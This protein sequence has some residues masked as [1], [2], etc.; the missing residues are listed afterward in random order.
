MHDQI[1]S[2][3]LLHCKLL[4]PK[5]WI[6]QTTNLLLSHM[7][8]SSKISLFKELADFWVVYHNSCKQ[9]TEVLSSTCNH[10]RSYF[11]VIYYAE[12]AF[13]LRLARKQIN[14]SLFQIFFFHFI[15]I[16]VLKYLG[17]I[18]DSNQ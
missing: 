18:L 4:S 10:S 14:T 2:L 15:Y 5:V 1:S 16:K 12:H 7:C 3:S 11:T 8:D 13:N 17:V 6:N 9:V